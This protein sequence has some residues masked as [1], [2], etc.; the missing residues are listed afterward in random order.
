[1]MMNGIMIQKNSSHMQ[2]NVKD[3][4]YNNA[5]ILID[6]PVGKTSFETVSS[7]KRML[8]VKKI[9]HSGTLDKF[10]SGL[11]VLCTG[12][13]TKLTRYFLESDKR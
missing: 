8:N 2:G 12:R 1:M 9:G 3:I 6:K 10:A 4:N 13:A 11:L 5:V 7:V